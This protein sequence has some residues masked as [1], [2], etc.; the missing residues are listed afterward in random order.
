[1]SSS[2]GN[3][4]TVKVPT[5]RGDITRAV[6]LIEEV[7]RLHG[8]DQYSDDADPWRCRSRLIDEAAGDPPRAAQAPVGCR[9]A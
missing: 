8:Y 5:R 6:D 3:V 9:P 7:A 4:F 2:D 1:M